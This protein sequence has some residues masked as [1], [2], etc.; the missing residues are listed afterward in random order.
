MGSSKRDGVTVTCARILDLYTRRHSRH[1]RR[2]PQHSPEPEYGADEAAVKKIAR[3]AP[4]TRSTG[5]RVRLGRSRPGIPERGARAGRPPQAGCRGSNGAPGGG[6]RGQGVRGSVGR[7]RCLRIVRMTSRASLVAITHMG[8]PRRGSRGHRPSKTRRIRSA[9]AQRQ[10]FSVPPARARSVPPPGSGRRTARARADRTR[11]RP[12]GPP[13]GLAPAHGAREYPWYKTRLIRGRGATAASL[14]EGDEDAPLGR[15]KKTVSPHRI[16]ED[17]T[18]AEL[19]DERDDGQP[20]RRTVPLHRAP[21]HAPQGDRASARPSARG[22]RPRAGVAADPGRGRADDHRGVRRLLPDA[23]EHDDRPGRRHGPEGARAARPGT[24]RPA[25]DRA[26]GDTGQRSGARH[27]HPAPDY[28]GSRT[29]Q[30]GS[31]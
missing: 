15:V 14:S 7:P 23:G 11:P 31:A 20:G 26:R 22:L 16:A 8:P 29:V 4:G 25:L 5:V 13:L 2:R 21:D 27:E 10:G 28:H 12:R 17:G 18:Y 19:S 6:P 9:Q 24:S 3:P 1:K 30:G